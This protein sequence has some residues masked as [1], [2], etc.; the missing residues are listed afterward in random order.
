M[1][2]SPAPTV[3]TTS[4]CCAGSS[5]VAPLTGRC[6]SGPSGA[7]KSTLAKLLM[8]FHDPSAGEIRLDG[9]DL[10]QI[11]LADLRRNVSILLQEA[12]IL[13]G[14]VA[15]NIAYAAPGASPE[16]IAAAARDAGAAEFI[17]SL[18]EGYE[19]DL[20]ERG[21]SLSGGQRQRIA[22]ARALLADAPVL[23]LDE[24]T[25]GLDS[26]SRDELIEPLRRL[27]AGRT[28]VI[29]SHD[30]VLAAEA[31]R[32]IQLVDGRVVGGRHSATRPAT[33]PLEDI[34]HA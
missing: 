22:I 2:E 4:T 14:S 8:R 26:R 11:R 32:V 13:H 16:Q 1:K 31:D 19:T 7:G 25:T 18:P 27:S 29:I 12:P 10:R 23:I 28:T 9:I 20:G 21:R 30:P 3:S 17:E 15:E 24:P 6:T 33:M 5:T 34:V